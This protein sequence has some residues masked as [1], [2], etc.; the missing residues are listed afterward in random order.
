MS[1]TWWSWPNVRLALIRAALFAPA[2]AILSGR[3]EL[4]VCAWVV[5][6]DAMFETWAKPRA[7]TIPRTMSLM[8]YAFV[9]A[10]LGF[11]AAYFQ[12]IYVTELH[13]TRSLTAALRQL[14]AAPAGSLQPAPFSKAAMPLCIPIVWVAEC[15]GLALATS[16]AWRRHAVA[17]FVG[18]LAIA[19]AFPIIDC[20]IFALLTDKPIEG[21]G[22]IGAALVCTMFLA[23]GSLP[24]L[25]G[26][27]ILHAAAGAIDRRLARA[28][29]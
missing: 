18:W 22:V 1:E 21:M 2:V 13:D 8:T 11:V 14:E 24:A 25:V 12:S 3:P 9:I 17:A 15:G 20:L 28:S 26:V 5:A 29:P 27:E 19:I 6:L 16:F 7:T 23:G 10:S 4:F